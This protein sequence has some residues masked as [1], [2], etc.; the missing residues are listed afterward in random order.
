M[1]KILFTIAFMT[2]IFMANALETRYFSVNF[3]KNGVESE[4]RGL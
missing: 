1:K 2:I 3:N 4:R